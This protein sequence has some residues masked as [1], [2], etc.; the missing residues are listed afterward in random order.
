MA[1][2]HA[3]STTAA[4]ANVHGEATHVGVYH[5]EPRS[6]RAPAAAIAIGLP[7]F[8]R[9][10]TERPLSPRDGRKA[11]GPAA[12]RRVTLAANRRRAFEDANQLQVAIASEAGAHNG[13]PL[14]QMIRDR[15][16]GSAARR[17]Q[18]QP[19]RTAIAISA[20]AWLLV[21]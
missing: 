16:A 7:A 13:A 18:Q 8:A 6:L 19:W 11:A 20:A 5:N 15:R 1:S 12:R 17:Q 14:N 9:Q 3:A 4:A 21:H 2:V 10:R